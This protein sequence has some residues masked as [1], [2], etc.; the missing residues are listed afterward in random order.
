MPQE[1]SRSMQVHQTDV[2]R[3]DKHL[4]SCRAFGIAVLASLSCAAP[5]PTL[6]QQ[7]SPVWSLSTVAGTGTLGDSGNGGLAT[8]ATINKPVGVAIDR[9]GNLYFSEADTTAGSVASVIRKVTPEGVISTIAG[10]LAKTGSSGDGGPAT[11]AL[12]SNPYGVEID[13]DG[14]LLIGD[15]TN[16]VIRKIDLSTGIITTIAGAHASGYS[17]DGGPATSARLNTA[18]TATGDGAGNIYIAD[19]KNNVIRKIDTSG[20]ISTFAGTGTA[21]HTG[22]GGPAKNAT[23]SGPYSVWAD[24]AGNLYIN[25]LGSGASY[26]RLIDTA[27]IIHTLAGIGTAGFTGEGGLGTAAEVNTPH[28][29][30]TDGLGNVY[31]ADETNQII[32][33]I[34]PAG[35]IVTIAGQHGSGGTTGDGGP[36]LSGKVWYPYGLAIDASNNLYEPDA[37]GNKIRKLSLN[38]A[39]PAT[40]SDATVTQ[41]LFVASTAAVTPSAATF[42]PSNEF[43]V[44][45]LSGCTL[46]TQ[47]AANAPCTV[48]ISFTPSAAGLR[49]AQ[50]SIIDGSGNASLIGITGMGTAPEAAFAPATISTVAGSGDAGFSNTAGPASSAQVSAPRGGMVDGAGNLYFADSG[51]NVIRRIDAASGTMATVAG[52]SHAGFSGDGSLATAAQLNAPAKVVVDAAGDLYIADTGNNAIRYVDAASGNISTIA[53]TGTSAYTGDGGA[54]T[55]ATLNHP[56]G[57]AVD[58]GGHVYVADTGNHAIRYFGKGGQISTFMGNG[59][60]GFAG[61]GGNVHDAVLN[62]P[63][64]VLLDGH[65]GVYV[66]DTG[67]SVVRM[68]P[69]TNKVATIA[70]TQGRDA[71]AGDGGLA[72]SATLANPSDIA[73]DAAGDLYIA[74]KDRIRIIDG[75]GGI[76]TIAGTGETGTYSGEGG[77]ATNAVLP[78]PAS[79]LFVDSAANVYVA[80]TSGNRLLEIASATPRTLSFGRQTPNT[81][82]ST[83]RVL[84]QSAG[85]SPLQLSG[86]TVIGPFSMESGDPT[87]CTPTTALAPG[88]SCSL[89]VSFSPTALGTFNGSVTIADNALNNSAS[90]QIIPLTGQGF[91]INTTSTTLTLSPG[92]PIYGQTTQ[93]VTTA[94]VAGGVGATGTVIF[95]LDGVTIGKVPL[96][97]ST[98]SLN[99]PSLQAGDYSVAASYAG[100]DNNSSSSGTALFTVQPAV[101]TVIA[102][103]ASRYTLY[104]PNPAFT[105]TIT[106]YVSGDAPGVVSG[107]PLITTTATQTSPLG[108]YPIAISHGTLSAANYTFVFVDGSLSVT[109]APPPDFTLTV[110]PSSVALENGGSA[111]FTFS[112]ASLYGYNGTVQFSCGAPANVHCSFTPSSLT[113]NPNGV[114]ASQLTVYLGSAY[115]GMFGGTPWLTLG[116]ALLMLGLALRR[117][118]L[119]SALT[120]SMA[121]LV[122]ACGLSGCGS[123]VNQLPGTGTSQM[124]VTATDSTGKLTHS[125]NVTLTIR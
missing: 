76:S 21:G 106:G 57:L 74:A 69:A 85:N 118:K 25:E 5:P 49:S 104:Q 94:T 50:L 23:L 47:L 82:G 62:A 110:S 43:S 100:D 70:G 80:E 103:N 40:P 109:T 112:L 75:N 17:G 86:I 33:M 15:I 125:A 90:T 68:V 72:A 7:L 91:V 60:A 66:A 24:P 98:A 30:V 6:G 52:T 108:S 111:T 35:N 34:N 84:L 89:N 26:V 79:N 56:Q 122:S 13:R 28:G 61:D 101:L 9:A 18:Y 102:A 46:G 42:T 45:T 41:K 64:A 97:G 2:R 22:D 29:T 77:A 39:L 48:P 88:T 87:S 38:T 14:N 67:N 123:A 119:A 54:A 65:G 19:N 93:A 116:G 92:S 53:G 1:R 59:T 3:R 4:S 115:A 8:K 124:T 11:A 107:S 121:L 44:G 78:S 20:M 73:M 95:T 51:N 10:T 96:S 99:L 31:V 16:Q 120:L 113:G 12:L 117:R 71:N 27:G 55:A 58:L 63:Q 81:A 36:A 105:Y 37:S 32:R 114:V 83:Q